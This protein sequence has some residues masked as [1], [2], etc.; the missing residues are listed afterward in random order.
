MEP[1]LAKND[2]S[3]KIRRKKNVSQSK[4]VCPLVGN[5]AH[6]DGAASVSLRAEAH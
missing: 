2:S 5:S 4:N 6:C 1:E 3:L